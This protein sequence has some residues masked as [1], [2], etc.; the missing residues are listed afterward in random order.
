MMLS[1]SEAWLGAYVQDVNGWM[2]FFL[3][4]A[5][6]DRSQ[7]NRELSGASSPSSPAAPGVGSRSFSRQPPWSFESPPARR[8]CRCSGRRGDA[9]AGLAAHLGVWN[10]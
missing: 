6:E 2:M 8:A 9:G 5:W 3:L 7:S 10:R 1:V 4:V